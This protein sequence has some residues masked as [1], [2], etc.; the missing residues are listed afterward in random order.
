MID[1]VDLR[2]N[3]LVIYRSNV[4]HCALFDGTALSD[5]P[6]NGRLTAN[7]FFSPKA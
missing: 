1:H 6:R 7:S 2:F 4:L 5:D 3:R